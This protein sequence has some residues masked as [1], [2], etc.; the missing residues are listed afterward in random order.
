[1]LLCRGNHRHRV[2]LILHG[3]MKDFGCIV[4]RCYTHHL[5][6]GR[7][8]RPVIADR[9][10]RSHER[11]GKAPFPRQEY[12]VKGRKV[13][14]QPTVVPEKIKTDAVIQIGDT[15]VAVDIV[16]KKLIMF[17][18]SVNS[19]V[20][21]PIKANDHQVGSSSS[22]SKYFQPRWCPPGLTRTQKRKLQRLRF[23][24]KKEQEFERLRDKQFNH[25]RPMVPQG[26]EWR[27][28]V[29]DQQA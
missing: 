28:K 29:V 10:D 21:R 1:M 19:P 22:V 18:K 17:D 20:Q 8:I 26:K 9:S 14:V 5:T 24:E 6:E 13:E 11:Q 4:I 12:R 15:K 23:Q 16:G 25:Y 27:V 3:S 7:R 2:F